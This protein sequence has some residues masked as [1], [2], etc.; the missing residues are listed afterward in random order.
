MKGNEERRVERG[1][2][3]RKGGGGRLKKSGRRDTYHLSAVVNKLISE[4]ICF[5]ETMYVSVIHMDI[6]I[7][8]HYNWLSA[9]QS[10][11]YLPHSMY[12]GSSK[13]WEN[14]FLGASDPTH[15]HP[16]QPNILNLWYAA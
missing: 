15:R 1:R 9:S 10:D 3:R 4:F 12:I 14:C 6:C 16:Y 13:E 8:H 2:R 7:F 5:I 11:T